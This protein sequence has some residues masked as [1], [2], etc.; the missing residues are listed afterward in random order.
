MEKKIEEYLIKKTKE[1][2]GECFKWESRNSRRSLD[3]LLFLPGGQLIIVEIKRPGGKFRPAQP[4]MI[5][6]L[7]GLGFRVE[8]IDSKEQIDQLFNTWNLN[9]I[10]T[11]KKLKSTS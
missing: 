7:R 10:T 9:H 2:G 11:K 1:A 5:K 3:R 6:L 4:Y 8:V